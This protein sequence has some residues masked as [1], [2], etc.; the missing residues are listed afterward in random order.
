MNDDRQ[1]FHHAAGSTADQ[2]LGGMLVMLAAS[3]SRPSL[4]SED[5]GVLVMVTIWLRSSSSSSFS[6]STSAT[7]SST[8]AAQSQADASALA[9]ARTFASVRISRSSTGRASTRVHIAVGHHVQPAG[10]RRTTRTHH[11]ELATNNQSSPSTHSAHGLSCTA[12]MIDVKLTETDLPWYFG[13]GKVVSFINA[14][15]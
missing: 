7:G 3:G 2:L 10:C 13:F 11:D 5:G 12:G 14:H 4:R 15:A 6:S 8:S 1:R 9:A